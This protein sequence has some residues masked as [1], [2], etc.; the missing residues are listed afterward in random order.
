MSELANRVKQMHP[1]DE[2]HLAL[3]CVMVCRSRGMCWTATRAISNLLFEEL[4]P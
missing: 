1:R 4:S 3:C 2:A